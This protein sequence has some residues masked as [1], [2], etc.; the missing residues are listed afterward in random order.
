MLTQ[1]EL[2]GKV[3]LERERRRVESEGEISRYIAV[4]IVRIS[5]GETRK[6]DLKIIFLLIFYLKSKLT[7]SRQKKVSRQVIY[8]E[9]LHTA[10]P[11]MSVLLLFSFPLQ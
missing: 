2:K 3:D 8:S 10:S 1:P 4:A 11:S 5:I 9:L 6:T 7:I